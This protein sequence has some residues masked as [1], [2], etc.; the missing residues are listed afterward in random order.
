MFETTQLLLWVLT[1]GFLLIAGLSTRR[2]R[3][4]AAQMDEWRALYQQ[5]NDLQ[6]EANRLMRELTDALKERL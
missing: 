2:T 5:S 1:F 6:T 3:Q 4:S